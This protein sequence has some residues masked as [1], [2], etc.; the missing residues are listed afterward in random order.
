MRIVLLLV[1]EQ[2]VEEENL[3]NIVL[4]ESNRNRKNRIFYLF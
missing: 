1:L 3:E 2:I 4:L